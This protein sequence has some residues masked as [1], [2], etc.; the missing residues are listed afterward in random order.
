MI[1]IKIKTPHQILF[2]ID[3]LYETLP[4]LL[5]FFHSQRADRAWEPN[6]MADWESP[7]LKK[8]WSFQYLSRI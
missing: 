4:D 6:L 1:S 5:R 2:I 7:L 3:Q 8:Q